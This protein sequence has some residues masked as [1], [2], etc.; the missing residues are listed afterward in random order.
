M[1]NLLELFPNFDCEDEPFHDASPDISG[2]SIYWV[3]YGSLI[4]CVLIFTDYERSILFFH[5]I[6][7]SIT[8]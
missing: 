3:R 6:C 2:Q 5:M 1:N 8:F 4:T 7:I